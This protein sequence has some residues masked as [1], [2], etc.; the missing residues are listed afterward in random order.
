MSMKP[1]LLASALA[2][3]AIPAHAATFTWAGGL[4]NSG[5]T[6][7]D[8]LLSP[9]V[10]ELTTGTT[11]LFGAS[12]FTN[13]SG[14]V[15]WVDGQVNF[16]TG[17]AVVNNGLW[18]ARGDNLFSSTSGPAGTFTNNGTFR[19][20]AGAGQTTLSSGIGFGFV[21]NG[22]IDAQ[23]GTIRFNTTSKTFNGG[24]VFTG[25]GAVEINGGSAFNGGFTSSN[26]TILG[27]TQTGTNAALTGSMT[28][29][30]GTLAGSW[31]VNNGATLNLSTAAGK[32]ISGASFVN[33]GTVNWSGGTVGINGGVS[34]V[35]K[36]LWEATSDNTL[37][38]TG[39]PATSFVNEGTFR[40]SAGTGVTTISP[41]VGLTFSNTGLMEVLSGT[42]Q[43]PNGWT[44]NGTLAGT[45]TIQTLSTL[46]NAG[47]VAPGAI[48]ST[49]TLTVVGNYAQSA[50]GTLAIQLA[51]S[52]AFD[53]LNITGTAA[54]NGTLALSCVLSC[55]I[56]TG[57]SFVILDSTGILSGTF[58]NI[59]LAGFLPDF[60]YGLEYDT[61]GRLVRL[62][63]LSAGTPVGPPPIPEPATWA[64][65]ILGF[66]LVGASVRRRTTAVTA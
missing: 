28:M 46:T 54:L 38:S 64:M 14:T 49:G 42:I 27:G 35:N 23:T 48:G 56:A 60:D 32:T 21:N 36:G 52:S 33:E 47:T 62:N 22:T 10:L 29:A 51:S 19:K 63:V 20:S 41:G 55:A 66:G 13:Q 7:P 57:D 45:G 53:L 5:V 12:G 11:K 24:T 30:D 39:G 2:L 6:S 65:M 17:A 26:L 59:T 58:A 37:S 8:P 25:A 31:K 34:A 4:Y 50:A 9:D 18:D 16:N 3:T 15:T 40:K 1:I 43:V 44:N 61:V